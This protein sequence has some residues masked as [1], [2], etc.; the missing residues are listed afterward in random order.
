MGGTANLT[1]ET[2]SA[3][4]RHTCGIAR[5]KRLFCWGDNRVGQLGDGT[6]TQR[7]VPVR[8]DVNASFVSVS[9]GGSHTC[10]VTETGITY[11]WGANES[12]QL[13]DGTVQQRNRPVTPGQ[14]A[15]GGP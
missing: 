8:V 4:Q 5:T 6:T 14:A 13:G 11:C 7:V 3:G 9:A 15:T 12:G 2:L 10:G 1:F